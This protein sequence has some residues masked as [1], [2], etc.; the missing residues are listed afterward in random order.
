MAV[1]MIAVIRSLGS[2]SFSFSLMCLAAI[3][4]EVIPTY[5]ALDGFMKMRRRNVERREI[6]I[7]DWNYY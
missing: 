5:G 2:H 4:P 7:N 3:F 1:I 6:M